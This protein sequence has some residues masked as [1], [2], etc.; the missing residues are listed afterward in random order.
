MSVPRVAVRVLALLITATAFV[1][2]GALASV[3]ESNVALWA[4]KESQLW[5]ASGYA[6]VV[7]IALALLLAMRLPSPGWLRSKHLTYASTLI[8][9]TLIL[10]LALDLGS[11]VPGYNSFVQP[12][13]VMPL[14]PS[15]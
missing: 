15:V 10:L 9:T 12:S 2:F 8:S 4:L 14:P 13:K 6:L 3:S 7:L 5:R 11:A 1:V